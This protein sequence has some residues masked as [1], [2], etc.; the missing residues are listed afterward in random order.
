MEMTRENKIQYFD[1]TDPAKMIWW[2][3]TDSG[4]KRNPKRFPAPMVG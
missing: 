1:K 3:K 2:V 4:P